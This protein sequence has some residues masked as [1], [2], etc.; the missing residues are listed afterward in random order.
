M[1]CSYVAAHGP[2]RGRAVREHGPYRDLKERKDESEGGRRVGKEGR[3]AGRRERRGRKE[4]REKEEKERNTE[5]KM[6]EQG[7]RLVPPD[8]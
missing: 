4:K 1:F 3:G 5:Q 8:P 2:P 7:A 6:T